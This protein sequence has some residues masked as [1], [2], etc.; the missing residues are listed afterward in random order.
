MPIKLILISLMNKLFL[1]ET[2]YLCLGLF[3]QQGNIFYF[4]KIYHFIMFIIPLQA[5][6]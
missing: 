6:H 5:T 1:I 2:L 3:P 4:K